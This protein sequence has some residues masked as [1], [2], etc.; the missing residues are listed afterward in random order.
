[1]VN[2]GSGLAVSDDGSIPY[3]YARVSVIPSNRFTL[4]A[5]RLSGLLSHRPFYG[6]ATMKS[7][8]LHYTSD[9]IFGRNIN[10]FF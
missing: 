4:V 3:D 5:L 10:R 1:M 7:R 6:T 9:L 8:E 2:P